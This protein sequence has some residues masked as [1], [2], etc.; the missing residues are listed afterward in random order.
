M[1]EFRFVAMDLISDG[2]LDLVIEERTPA[3]ER[4]GYVPA[5]NYAIQLHHTKVKV[6]RIS[7]RIGDNRLIYYGGHIG[8]EVLEEFRGNGYAAKACMLVARVA[9]AHGLD[10]L[11]ITCN[12]DS[13]PSRRT[14]EKLGA[15]LIE[16][17]DLPPD[18]DMYQEGERQ[19]CRYEWTLTD[20]PTPRDQ[21]GFPAIL[22]K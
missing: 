2:E 3:N 7:L 14:C 4:K 9:V 13:L 5:Y 18:N 11:I 17:V 20:A 16:T 6:G 12:P 10:R 19:K 21:P 1:G 15:R 8:Y 22:I